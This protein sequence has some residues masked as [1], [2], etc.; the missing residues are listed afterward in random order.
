[1]NNQTPIKLEKNTRSLDRKEEALGA[2]WVLNNRAIDPPLSQGP[3]LF[4]GKNSK[5]PTS[6]AGV[7]SSS[8]ERLLISTQSFSDATIV[9]ATQDAV[10]RGV[11]IYMLVDKKDLMLFSRTQIVSHF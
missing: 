11:R 10:Q 5:I 7:I 3:F 8:T 6:I 1:M 9:Q 4:S 2:C